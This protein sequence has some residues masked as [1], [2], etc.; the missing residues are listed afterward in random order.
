MNT[1]YLSLRLDVS[2]KQDLLKVA[3]KIFFYNFKTSF[4][5]DHHTDSSPTFY[6]PQK[7]RHHHRN[8]TVCPSACLF[9]LLFRSSFSWVNAVTIYWISV[10]VCRLVEHHKNCV[11]RNTEVP[12]QRSR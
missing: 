1:V 2:G 4:E 11:V 5:V 10:K 9:L 12:V 6:M 7:K 3:N 8:V